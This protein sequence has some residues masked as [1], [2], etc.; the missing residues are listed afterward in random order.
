MRFSIPKLASRRLVTIASAIALSWIIFMLFLPSDHAFR[1]FLRFNWGRASGY[2]REIDHSWIWKPKQYDVDFVEDVGLLIKTGYGTR[3]RVLA[4]MEA[5]GLR[6][7]SNAVIVVG[8]FGSRIQGDRINVDVHDVV[9]RLL[10]DHAVAGLLDAPRVLRY[11]ELQQAISIQDEGRAQEIG[12][13]EGW[14]LDALKVISVL[15][16]V[17]DDMWLT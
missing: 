4:Q 7:T 13:K 16:K 8:D 15:Y 3:H 14:N 11:K 17:L 6:E 2:I 12:E 10:K 9:E 5:L 1:S